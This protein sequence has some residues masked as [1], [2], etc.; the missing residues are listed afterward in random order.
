MRCNNIRIV[1]TDFG[2]F[3]GNESCK[4]DPYEAGIILSFLVEGFFKLIG[5]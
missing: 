1:A 4:L 5:R 2:E 3:L